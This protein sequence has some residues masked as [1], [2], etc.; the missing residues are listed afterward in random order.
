VDVKEEAKE[1]EY[2]MEMVFDSYIDEKLYFL[3]KWTPL[4]PSMNGLRYD[5]HYCNLYTRRIKSNVIN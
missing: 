3:L 5:I 4:Y 2:G 1:T